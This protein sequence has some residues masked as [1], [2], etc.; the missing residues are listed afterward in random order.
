MSQLAEDMEMKSNGMIKVSQTAY[1]GCKIT[2]G[3]AVY[4]VKTDLSHTRFVKEHGDVKL[5]PY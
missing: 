3:G 2:I 4:H 1:S 5:E